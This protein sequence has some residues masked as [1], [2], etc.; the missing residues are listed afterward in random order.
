MEQ[1]NIVDVIGESAASIVYLAFDHSLHRH[2]ALREY[3][4]RGITAR[5][6]DLSLRPKSKEDY[7]PFQAG[8]RGF[9]NEAL[10]LSRLQSPSL[11]QIRRYWEANNTAYAVM[12]LYEGMTL[13]QAFAERRITINEDWVRALILHLLNAV[14]A[15]HRAQSCH[16]NISPA[17]ILVREDGP[18]LL[19]EIDAAQLVIAETLGR[20]SGTLARGFAPIELYPEMA[21]AQQGAWTDIYSIAAVA[22]YLI[23]CKA[24]PPAMQ[25]IVND[26]LRPAREIG[27]GAYSGALLAALD[28]ALSVRPEQRIQTVSAMRM[29]LNAQGKGP[30]S[31]ASRATHG[32]EAIRSHRESLATQTQARPVTA[33]AALE[34]H[35]PLKPIKPETETETEPDW[36]LPA[37]QQKNTFPAASRSRKSALIASGIVLVAGVALGL[38]VGGGHL[39]GSDD[40]E[41]NDSGATVATAEQRQAAPPASTPSEAP[42]AEIPPFGSPLP[43]PVARNETAPA[44]SSP[45]VEAPAPA[46]GRFGESPVIPPQAA[47]TAPPRQ[48]MPPKAAATPEKP[49]PAEPSQ[50][51]QAKAKEAERLAA[52]EREQ[53]RVASTIDQITAYEAYLGRYPTG[54]NHVAARQRLAELRLRAKSQPDL[55]AAQRS[56]SKTP[57]TSTADRSTSAKAA[58]SKSAA[59]DAQASST[60]APATADSRTRTP[61]PAADTQVAART[62]RSAASSTASPAS[63]SPVPVRPSSSP[64]TS[65]ATEPAGIPDTA[66]APGRKTYR[67]A[68]QTMTGDFTADPSTGLVSGKGRIV[69]NNGDRFDGTLVKGSKEGKGQFVWSNGQR[70][71]GD[72]ARNEPNGRGTLVFANGNRYEGDIRNGLPDGRGVLVFSD[73]S[74]Y[75]GQ[76]R[77]GVPN[78]RG[79]QVFADGTRY[80]GDVRDGLPHGQGVT[81]FR[82]GDVYVGSVARGRSSGQGRLTWA[83]GAVWEGEFRDGQRTANGRLLAASGDTSASGT[84]QAATSESDAAGDE[85]TRR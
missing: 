1:L 28:S 42:A 24:P 33:T 16:G 44:P 29:I 69:W 53:W 36:R 4:P 56:Q 70:Y 63:Q 30:E 35:K 11:I 37:S 34:P 51:E 32:R 79:V 59:S 10:L 6:V 15:V 50:E 60:P 20:E 81:R 66:S 45:A 65:P 55:A 21:G 18:P 84:S 78:G 47:I 39:F 41:D 9:I 49:V 52:A 43:A 48:T 3:L 80:E 83:N 75:E 68:D 77:N 57:D 5:D 26:T 67:H 14:E 61:A 2:M 27:G 72:W 19:M 74:R 31:P 73:G 54:A 40:S 85:N 23:A 22:Y 58:G 8:L 82:N 12:P 38:A 71:N 64:S 62:E 17:N 7:V 13:Q 25:R 76:I 46:V